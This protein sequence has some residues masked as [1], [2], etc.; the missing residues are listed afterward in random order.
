MLDEFKEEHTRLGQKLP[1]RLTKVLTRYEGD[2]EI[3][4]DDYVNMDAEKSTSIFDNPLL[5]RFLTFLNRH[6]IWKVR[7]PLNRH[8][9]VGLD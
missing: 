2:Q 6:V 5:V 9:S 1:V 4:L 7:L 3:S 8:K